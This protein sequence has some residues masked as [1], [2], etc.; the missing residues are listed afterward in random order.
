MKVRNLII[1]YDEHKCRIGE[2]NGTL[3]TISIVETQPGGKKKTVHSDIRFESRDKRQEYRTLLKLFR[4][5]QAD[6]ERRAA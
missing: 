2:Q 6:A 1:S 5:S 4:R 3:K